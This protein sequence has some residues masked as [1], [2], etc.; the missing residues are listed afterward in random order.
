[1]ATDSDNL[2]SAYGKTGR[3]GLTSAQRSYAETLSTPQRE[4]F[5]QMP[6]NDRNAMLAEAN[7][8]LGEQHQKPEKPVKQE[9]EAGK[10]IVIRDRQVNVKAPRKG[11]ADAGG[12]GSGGTGTY[13]LLGNTSG[14]TVALSL[15]Y[16]AIRNL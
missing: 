3:D 8:P 2:Y 16:N 12:A 14:V 11:L 13:N 4:A 5:E 7:R 15:Q 6:S 1:M 9:L 10:G